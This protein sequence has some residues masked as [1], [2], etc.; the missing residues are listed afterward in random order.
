MQVLP[1]ILYSHKLTP[2]RQKRRLWVQT[3]RTAN[4]G[5]KCSRKESQDG[6]KHVTLVRVV[7]YSLRISIDGT[8]FN[9][10]EKRRSPGPVGF[11]P[12]SPLR[13]TIIAKQSDG[14][15]RYLS[16]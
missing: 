9:F 11:Q 13:R 8:W 14:S 4:P 2:C 5:A 3:R 12:F 16:F 15:Q 6:E 7:F 10:Q 1:I